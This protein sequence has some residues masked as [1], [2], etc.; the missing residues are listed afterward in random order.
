MKIKYSADVISPRFLF[1][2]ADIVPFKNIQK[3]CIHLC[4]HLKNK[5]N[6][7][8][9]KERKRNEFNNFYASDFSCLIASSKNKFKNYLY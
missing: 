9:H 5:L 4:F 3:I 2:G 8:K 1:L 6:K 7:A